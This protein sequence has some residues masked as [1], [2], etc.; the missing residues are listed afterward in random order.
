[1]P[2]VAQVY[3]SA[4]C[5]TVVTTTWANSCGLL[6]KQVANGAKTF[7]HLRDVPVLIAACVRKCVELSGWLNFTRVSQGA[8][9]VRAKEEEKRR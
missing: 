7:T 5:V 1:M 4:I 6:A 9:S 8:N 3:T 2:D